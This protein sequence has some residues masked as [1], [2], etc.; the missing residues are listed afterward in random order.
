MNHKKGFTLLEMMIVLS[1]IALVF[2]ITLPNIQ[3]KE[4]IIQKKGCEALT[5]VVNGQIL[6]YEI[7]HLHSPRSVDDLIQEG[8]LK[9]AQKRCPNGKKIVIINGQAYA[10]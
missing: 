4:K 9:A 6:L 7:E 5:E 10:K 3:Q 8:Y 2:L 1:M